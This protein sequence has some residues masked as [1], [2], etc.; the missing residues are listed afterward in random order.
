M[1]SDKV[2]QVVA[3]RIV[4]L[5]MMLSGLALGVVASSAPVMARGTHRDD[6]SGYSMSLVVSATNLQYGQNAT[7]TAT[8]SYPASNPP[9]PTPRNFHILIDGYGYT[10]TVYMT[11]TSPVVSFYGGTGNQLPGQHTATA[12]Y[13]DPTTN[14]QVTSSLVTWTV[15]KVDG[16][17]AFICR[18]TDFTQAGQ[19][20][21]FFTDL[22]SS[23]T[24]DWSKAKVT[25][26]FVGPT[27]VVSPPLVRDNNGNVSTP[28]PTQVGDY[29]VQCIFSGTDYFTPGQV[30]LPVT[31][32]NNYALGSAKLYSS[33]TPLH[34]N[35]TNPFML[36]IVLHAA[37]GFPVPTGQVYFKFA[38]GTYGP[39][40]L[41]ADGTLLAAFKPTVPLGDSISSITVEYMGDTIYGRQTRSF[42]QTNPPIPDNAGGSGSS[43]L[44]AG[45]TA[46]PNPHATVTV[47]VTATATATTTA[48]T[49]TQ[50]AA[51]ASNSPMT[52]VSAGAGPNWALIVG[53]IVAGLALIGGGVGGFLVWRARRAPL[54]SPAEPSSA[55]SPYGQDRQYGQYGQYGQSSQYAQRD[56][57]WNNSD[58]STYPDQTP[59]TAP[60]PRF[61]PPADDAHW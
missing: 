40:T 31:V 17:F 41:N 29:Q 22:A 15:E 10:G 42:S 20:M 18:G 12:V 14:A 9:D 13:V 49:T 37:Q 43:N 32:S 26:K 35:T 45:P 6:T 19:T 5:L 58:A 44:G 57:G 50:S 52:S 21:Q 55:Q 1:K 51:G 36:Y 23:F 48:T 4:A 59:A 28:A 39:G 25:I 46:T 53:L 11:E 56:T 34:L 61:R 60:T 8:L 47:T 30:N 7:L 16:Q 2:V 24:P 33:P 38:N 3:L 27:T 54:A